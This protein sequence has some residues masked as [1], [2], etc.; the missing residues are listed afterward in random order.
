VVEFIRNILGPI[1][2]SDEIEDIKIFVQF[3]LYLDGGPV[4]MAVQ[5]FALMA[6]VT[7]K[8]G[9]AKKEI[10]LAN[11]NLELL[12]HDRFLNLFSD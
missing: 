5:A 8:M 3:S 12:I 11:A 9:G 2:E 7:D 1:F 6:L 10:V 4:V